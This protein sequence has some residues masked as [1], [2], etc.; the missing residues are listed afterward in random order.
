MEAD[1]LKLE[2]QID[3]IID[4]DKNKINMN[5][6]GSSVPIKTSTILPNM[7]KILIFLGV[8][9]E[10]E[11]KIVKKIDK[12]NLKVKYFSVYKNSKYNLLKYA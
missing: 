9:F 3:M 4:D 2:K 10:S 6:P 11:K 12:L 1:I 8:N 5:L 7:N